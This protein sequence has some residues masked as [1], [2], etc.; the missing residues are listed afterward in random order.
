[1]CFDK[2][3]VLYYE[4]LLFDLVHKNINIYFYIDNF[5]TMQQINSDTELISNH[6]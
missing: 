4:H 5:V 2:N 3:V 6:L 1:M